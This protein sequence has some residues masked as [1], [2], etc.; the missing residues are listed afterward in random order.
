MNKDEQK[1]TDVIE[2]VCEEICNDYCRYS[3]HASGE[4]RED[5]TCGHYDDC[6]LNKLY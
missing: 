5:G 2:E 1:I 4:I 3:Y 6:P